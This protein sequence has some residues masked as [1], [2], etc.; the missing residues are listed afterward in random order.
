VRSL[1][2]VNQYFLTYKWRLL[3]GIVFIVLSNYFGVLA[4]GVI[5]E[6]IDTII[7]EAKHSNW[8]RDTSFQQAF[9]Q[10]FYNQ[11]LMFTGLAVLFALLRGVFLF[12]TRQTIIVMSRHIEFD[13]KNDIY[14]HLQRLD[15]DFY[16]RNNTGDIM[17]RISED[18]SRVRMYTGPG[19]M[20][21]LNLV[22]LSALVVYR[23]FEVAP[24]LTLYAVIP[25][26]V[27]LVTI[28]Y[29]NQIVERKSELIQAQ[30]SN[31]TTMAQ[32]TFSGIR[33]IKAFVQENNFINR[34]AKESEEY[35]SRT[36]SMVR[37]DAFFYPVMLL[38]VGMSTVITI[39]V[40]G[41]QVI[42][43]EITPGVIAE[44]IIYIN[45]VT[46]PFAMVGWVSALIQR[47]AVSQER[48]NKILETQ[49]SMS[50]GNV[51]QKELNGTIEF[52]NVTYTYPNTGI[53]ALHNI[54]FK[55]KQGERLAVVG[56]T[57]SGKSTL[58]ALL[59]R[60]FDTTEGEVLIDNR[61]IKQYDAETL[62]K[63]LA[64]VPQDVFLFSDTIANNIAFGETETVQPKV[65]EVAT[66]ASFHNEA[67]VM[68]K[69]YETVIG[70]RGITLSGG[71][72]Q[73]VS[74]ARALM[75]DAPVL[76]LDDCLSAVDAHTEREIFHNLLTFIKNRTTVLVTHRVSAAA[77]FDRILVLHH[78]EMVEMGTHEELMRRDG[79]YKKMV[80]LQ[81]KNENLLS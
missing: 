45:M 40:G 26:P 63:N 68:Q 8:F 51:T 21:T 81:N 73:R 11:V 27:M 4:P 35:R 72:K 52:K 5:R 32:E 36:L 9:S 48:I 53:T 20:Y 22:V 33:V 7:A 19:I 25:L 38:L 13:Q 15:Y 31:L 54:N 18:V 37:T 39:F 61:N 71:Q 44:F 74:I 77:E 49:P 64:Y 34:F 75:R 67:L 12:F 41:R 16:K 69:G 2:A 55:L 28:Y 50:F 59:T 78:G 58:A 24:T 46:W 79:Y 56:K 65:E 47:A 23:M 70:E 57:G 30:L 60:M 66:F 42:N 10:H 1:K 14:Q 29:V 6:A 43:G 62:R 76:V 17:T 80:D 3:F